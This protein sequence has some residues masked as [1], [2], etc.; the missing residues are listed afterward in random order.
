MDLVSIL[1]D[2][3]RDMVAGFVRTVPQLGIAFLVLLVTWGL[4][5][6]VRTVVR[7]VAGQAGARPSLVGLFATLAGI[8][9]WIFGILVA[10]AVLLPGVTAGSLLTILGFGSVAIGFAFRDIFE[11]F[12]AGVLIMMRRKMRIGDLI[13]CEQ[14]E[15]RVEQITLRET[16]LRRLDSQ[17]TIVPN[18]YLFK[19]PVRIVTDADLR[20]HE[21]VVGVSYDTDLDAAA[22]TIKGAIRDLELVN[23]SRGVD[24]FA[25]EFGDS[26][27]DFTVRWWSGS[28]QIEMHRSRDQVVRAIKRALDAAEIEIPFPQ[29]TLHFPGALK[30]DQGDSRLSG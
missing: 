3:V 12:L 30:V 7:R 5:N 11:N 24:V 2:R 17:L 20:R 15:G 4:A 25:R 22:D 13:E 29:R 8:L 1:L 16:Y 28:N 9:V 23:R 19:N 6:G 14:C 18:S 21:I 27:I 10:L 26:S